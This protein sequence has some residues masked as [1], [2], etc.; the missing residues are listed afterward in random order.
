MLDHLRLFLDIVRTKSL[1]RGAA[2]NQISQPAASQYLHDVEGRL[3]VSL[4]DRSTRPFTLTAAGRLYHEYARDML[5]RHEEFTAAL[6]TWKAEV[7]GT[8]RVASIYSVGLSEMSHLKEEFS[9]RCPKAKLEV[10]Y[11]RPEKVYEAVVYDRADL[12]LVSYAESTRELM[13]LPWRREEMV[14]AA[15]PSHPLARRAVVRAADL[16]GQDFVAFDE[17][18]PIRHEIDRFLRDHGVEVTVAMHF[19]NVQMIKE[20]VAVSAAIS[21]VPARVLREEVRQGRMAAV[22]LEAELVRPLGIV[23]RRR[24]KFHRAAESF[25]ALLQEQPQPDR[26][27]TPS[28]DTLQ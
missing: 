26:R 8:V 1:S 19:D 7:E 2:L 21:I 5:R 12:G 20:A 10:E 4:L 15:A 17:D 28:R 25:L 6:E 23:H 27:D 18:L 13:A 9:R 14:V 11:L 3:G 22:P 24:K 16:Q